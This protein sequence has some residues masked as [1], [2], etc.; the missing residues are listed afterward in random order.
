M[1]GVAIL[2]I[3]NKLENS[4]ASTSYLILGDQASLS[5]NFTALVHTSSAK[6]EF[7]SVFL[8]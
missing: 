3:H 2:L 7:G 4:F 6:A 1:N 8:L 5:L